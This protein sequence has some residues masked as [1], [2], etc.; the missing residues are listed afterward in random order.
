MVLSSKEYH[1]RTL[2][3]LCLILLCLSKQLS[4]QGQWMLIDSSG[5]A[6]TMSN[7]ACECIAYSRQAD[8][9]QIAHRGYAPV[10]NIWVNQ[11]DG[12]MTYY[13]RDLA[14]NFEY[15]PAQKPTSVAG[16]TAYITFSAFTSNNPVIFQMIAQY[17]Q[18]GWF[19]SDW[20]SPRDVG[21]GDVGAYLVVGKMFEDG[22]M[23]V[24]ATTA[25]D[26]ISRIQYRT[27]DST[28]TN[29]LAA[30]T[31]AWGKGYWGFDINGG[32]AYVFYGEY[33][34]PNLPVIY[35]RT[36][37][38]GITWSGEQL[39]DMVWPMPYGENDIYY[40]QCAVTDSGRPLLVF[41]NMDRSDQVYPHYSKIY[42]A[43]TPGQPCVEVSSTFGAPDS[44]CMYPTIA[45]GGNS[46]AVVYAMPGNNLDDSLCR[47]DLYMNWSSD[48]GRTWGTPQ[49]VT[50]DFYGRPG[51]QQLAKRIDTL[52]NRVYYTFAS[53]MFKGHDP[54]YLA[55]HGEDDWP[56]RIYCGYESA[57]AIAEPPI[58]ENINCEYDMAVVPSPFSTSVTFMIQGEGKGRTSEFR[59]YDSCGK[60][61]RSMVMPG[62][63]RSPLVATWDGRDHRHCPVP[64]GVYFVR[65]NDEERNLVKKIVKLE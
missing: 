16:N 48:N 60:L 19:S 15:G 45:T 50:A 3:W 64:A 37:T 41:D 21:P 33:D 26:T 23:L 28:L 6:C 58:Q 38:N 31:L 25:Q 47:N 11:M 53:D 43:H 44:E 65:V 29:Q 30:D 56:I 42:V 49:N 46:V 13:T 52:R 27:L 18:G 20:D 9:F 24:I 1:M 4:A 36:S 57:T 14:Y 22:N 32:I 12:E 54:L 35:Y 62:A 40:T 59:I 8:A 51:L 34:W 39:Y 61:V 2:F 63:G 17:E 10:S 55:M 7:Q 5:V